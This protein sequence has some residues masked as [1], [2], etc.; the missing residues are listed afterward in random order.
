MHV[1]MPNGGMIRIKKLGRDFD[2][3]NKAAALEAMASFA[4]T[5]FRD[6]LTKVTVPT[7][8]IHCDGD[9]TVPYEGSGARTH[10]AIAGSELH[11]IAGAPHGA[12][13][14]DADEFNRVVLAFLKK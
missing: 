2:P 11:V 5:D 7:L 12:N 8:V 14:S 10:A 13:V 6:D 3:T 9:A 4:N 1:D